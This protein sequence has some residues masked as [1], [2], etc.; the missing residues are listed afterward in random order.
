MHTVGVHTDYLFSHDIGSAESRIEIAFISQLRR[1]NGWQQMAALVSLQASD[2]RGSIFTIISSSWHACNFRNV[3]QRE[4]F[5]LLFL[6]T[7]NK[8]VYFCDRCPLRRFGALFSARERLTSQLTGLEHLFTTRPFH[9]PHNPPFAFIKFDFYREEGG[10]MFRRKD[11]AI[12][13]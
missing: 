2:C 1:C 13:K 5:S 8:A 10:N 11:R 9:T 6:L 7:K 4:I 3:K 12:D